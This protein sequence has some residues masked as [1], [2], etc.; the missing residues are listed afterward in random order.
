MLLFS[1][2]FIEDR[3][4]SAKT[5]V[6]VALMLFACI[7]GNDVDSK[8]RAEEGLFAEKLAEK[9]TLPEILERNDTIA[10]AYEER[11]RKIAEAVDAYV[12]KLEIAMEKEKRKADL[13]TIKTL[14]KL[15]EGAKKQHAKPC[16]QFERLPTKLAAPLTE[17]NKAKSRTNKVFVNVLEKEKAAAIR[18]DAIDEAKEIDDFLVWAFLPKSLE[19]AFGETASFSNK[20]FL[21]IDERKSWQ[22]AYDWCRER[23][24][25]LAS[26]VGREEQAF[27]FRKIMKQTKDSSWIGGV[28]IGNRWQWTDGTPFA[29]SAWAQGQPSGSPTEIRLAFGYGDNG[30]WDDVNPQNGDLPFIVQWVLY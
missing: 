18:R 11:N 24:G 26:V 21:K 9:E 30:G 23:N 14:E 28:R 2:S 6:C 27:L 19:R 10:Q 13:E 17:M 29:F 25:D 8:L 5:I 4:L 16:I 15:I 22:D 3:C 7:A 1:R 12:K 20:I